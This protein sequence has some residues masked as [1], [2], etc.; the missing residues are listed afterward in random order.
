MALFDGVPVICLPGNPVSTL[1]SFRLFVAPALGNVAQ[2]A[3]ARLGAAVTGI[4]GREQFRRGRVV[5]QSDGT[6]MAHILGGAGSHLI[7]Q[8]EEATHLIRVAAGAVV[9]AG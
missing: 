4:A 2:E 8:A 3:W 9:Q 6:T 7:T 5:Y 1:V